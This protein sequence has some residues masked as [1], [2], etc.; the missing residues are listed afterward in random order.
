MKKL[1]EVLNSDRGSMVVSAL[2]GLGLATMFR[3]TCKGASCIVVQAPDVEQLR[4]HIY[5][6]DGSCYRYMPVASKCDATAKTPSQK[7][8]QQPRMMQ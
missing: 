1:L 2:L 3:Q 8:A 7:E 6:I 4:N 5:E